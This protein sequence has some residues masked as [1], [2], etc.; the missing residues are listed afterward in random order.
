MTFFSSLYCLDFLSAIPQPLGMA[1]MPIERA[2]FSSQNYANRSSFEVQIRASK[3]DIVCWRRISKLEFLSKFR[4]R[5]SWL[6]YNDYQDS[7]VTKM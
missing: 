1:E 6:D 2:L 5:F 3:T 4:L 7:E